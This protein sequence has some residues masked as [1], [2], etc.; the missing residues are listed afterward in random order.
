M[1]RS[2]AE[3]NKILDS[4]NARRSGVSQGE[5]ER[6]LI[7]HG[8]T[9]EQ[10][11]NGV[12]VYLHHRGNLKRKRRGC[13]AEYTAILEAFEADRKRPKECIDYLKLKGYTFRQAQSAVYKYRRSKGLT[14]R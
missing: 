5:C 4:A 13:T 2:Q 7:E 14:M 9:Y 8:C 1:R 6:I 3:Y 11:K 10:A 12:Y